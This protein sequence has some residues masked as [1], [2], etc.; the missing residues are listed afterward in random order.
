MLTQ[1]LPLGE[2]GARWAGGEVWWLCHANH[3][4]AHCRALV[5]TRLGTATRSPPSQR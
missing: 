5:K 2:E 4:H 3:L 1:E